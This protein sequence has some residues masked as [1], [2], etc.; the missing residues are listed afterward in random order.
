MIQNDWRITQKRIANH[1]GID[2]KGNHYTSDDEVK[3]AIASWI[4]EKSKEFF[5]DGIK[6]L[7]TLWEKCVSLNG[8]GAAPGI[9]TRGSPSSGGGGPSTVIDT[10]FSPRINRKPRSGIFIVRSRKR[11][12]NYVSR[13][14]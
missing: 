13:K 10:I 5:S 3:A 11:S 9:G 1:I 12:A 7:V 8:P 6:K 14:C 2:L 4:R